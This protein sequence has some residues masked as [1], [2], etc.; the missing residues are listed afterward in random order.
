MK[1]HLK[2][3]TKPHCL[4]LSCSPFFFF[5]FD[6]DLTRDIK[7]K[8]LKKRKER[9]EEV[10][11]TLSFLS[12]SPDMS[13]SFV[14][15]S[16][17]SNQVQTEFQNTIITMSD[18][19]RAMI[20]TYQRCKANGLFIVTCSNCSDV[21]LEKISSIITTCTCLISRHGVLVKESAPENFSA[22]TTFKIGVALTPV[23]VLLL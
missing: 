9:E 12:F 23:A 22:S 20:S 3:E 6:P 4:L 8:I 17:P 7:K 10:S 21:L 14:N 1:P 5:F 18:G 13:Q 15:E 19:R 2:N 11:L 16:V